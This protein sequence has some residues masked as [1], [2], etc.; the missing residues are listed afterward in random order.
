MENKRPA[1]IKINKNSE[2][3]VAFK[4]DSSPNKDEIYSSSE[5]QSPTLMTSRKKNR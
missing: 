5:A 1:Q 4:V 3:I 2:G